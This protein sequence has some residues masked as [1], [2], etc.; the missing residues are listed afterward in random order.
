VW[1]S[2]RGAGSLESAFQ[3]R[4]LLQLQLFHAMGG[5]LLFKLQ[6]GI[7]MGPGLSAR[8]P[9]RP[10][11]RP[12]HSG[13]DQH[14]KKKKRFHLPFFFFQIQPEAAVTVQWQPESI[15]LDFGSLLLST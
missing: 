13:V 8:P 14:K 9:A 10:P 2:S 1:I 6:H 7:M 4:P 3:S 15:S 11:A 5:G 12:V